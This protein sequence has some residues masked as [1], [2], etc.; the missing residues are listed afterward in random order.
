MDRSKTTPLHLAAENGHDRLIL[1]L[2][3]NGAN[4]AQEDAYGRNLLELAILRNQVMA[5]LRVKKYLVVLLF[6][7]GG[8]SLPIIVFLG[9]ASIRGKLKLSVRG[10]Q[11]FFHTW[12]NTY[13]YS[14]WNF[15]F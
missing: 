5:F 7:L 1:L 6:C 8:K 3:E 10:K 11:K 12:K 14:T 4:I 13:I 15:P 2:L 9:G